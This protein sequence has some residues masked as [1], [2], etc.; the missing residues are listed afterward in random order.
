MADVDPTLGQ[1]ILDVAQRQWVP[2][3]HHYDQTDH[4]WRAIEISEGAAH[5]PELPRSEAARRIALTPPAARLGLVPK[6]R[7]SG[8]RARLFGISK[9]GDRYL[10]TLLIHGA[11]SALGRVRDK[12]YPR[13]LWLGKMR[14]RRHPNIVAVAIAN[15]NARIAWG[16]LTSDS[17]YD[18]SLS[19]GAA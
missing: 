6:Q 10:R 13:S 3:V 8:V 7:S 16:L 18:A 1:Q 9:R 14:Q 19:V 5:G 17:V 2:H 12:N 11:R 4:F 15:K